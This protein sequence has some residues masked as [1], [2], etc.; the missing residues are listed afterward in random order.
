MALQTMYINATEV[1]CYR[2]GWKSDIAR[3]GTASGGHYTDSQIKFTPSAEDLVKL[4]NARITSVTASL[5]F[6]KLGSSG[7][8][9]IRFGFS[10]GDNYWIT[11]TNAYNQVRWPSIWTGNSL[12][13]SSNWGARFLAQLKD[14]S[15]VTIYIENNEMVVPSGKNYASNY[16]GIKLPS[17]LTVTYEPLSSELEISDGQSFDLGILNTVSLKRYSSD[18]TETATLRYIPEEEEEEEQN[19]I[20]T[21]F[22]N[23]DSSF[24]FILPLSIANHSKNNSSISG[25]IILSTAQ[26]GTT[27]G[28]DKTYNININIPSN[29]FFSKGDNWTIEGV[30]DING[31]ESEYFIQ[32]LSRAQITCNFKQY[33]NED[34]E[35]TDEATITSCIIENSKLGISEKM[36]EGN[37]NTFTYTTSSTLKVAG[38]IF[39]NII[40]ENSRGHKKIFQTETFSIQPYSIPQITDISVIRINEAGAPTEVGNFLKWSGIL[41]YSNV[42]YSSSENNVN[43][44]VSL[45]L[46][47]PNILKTSTVETTFKVNSND[48]NNNAGNFSV[49]LIDT[50]IT[51]GLFSTDESY[52][53]KAIVQDSFGNQSIER[54]ATLSTTKYLIHFSNG[55][56]ALGLGSAAIYD[57]KITCG[58]D[59]FFKSDSG[60]LKITE[61]GTEA[62]DREGAWNNI[63]SQGGIINKLTIQDSNN[64]LDK[65]RP[66]LNLIPVI[67]EENFGKIQVKAGGE[68]TLLWGDLEVWDP[69][70]P[71]E[72]EKAA[73]TLYKGF[74]EFPNLKIGYSKPVDEKD[75]WTEYNILHSNNFLQEN[76]LLK[77]QNDS[78]KRVILE[79]SMDGVQWTN[80]GNDTHQ[81]SIQMPI[82]NFRK[83]I[84]FSGFICSDNTKTYTE[85]ADGT[86]EGTR[87][88]YGRP[89]PSGWVASTNW[90]IGVYYDPAKNTFYISFPS[91]YSGSDWTSVQKSTI[92]L[93]VDYIE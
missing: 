73:L 38:D 87:P 69:G 77:Y 11:V 75:V 27:I 47:Y 42:I 13:D 30:S 70:A 41:K 18:Y 3:F 79:H 80:H 50:S 72:Q 55:G 82:S 29:I 54:T 57:Q 20:L 67:G 33:K 84:G 86:V 7:T 85:A 59:M 14:N 1:W 92:T 4:R 6:A 68:E 74:G 15:S 51:G 71:G 81:V 16:G 83:I 90:S 5:T 26:N 56:G 2:G 64:S 65:E 9:T 52:E 63:V 21:N 93:I 61:G 23:N 58:F 78:I 40:V 53:I 46:Y 91:Q 45:T 24:S 66:C 25:Q 17:Y 43:V 62:I 76:Y 32:D 89:I 49:N 37:N 8:K 10:K 12:D 88:F 48:L 36:D 35:F 60:A 44:P 31:I 19:L 34:E 28:E 22:S 39:F